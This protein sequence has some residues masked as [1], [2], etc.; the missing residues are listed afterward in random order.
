[1]EPPKTG[2]TINLGAILIHHQRVEQMARRKLRAVIQIG[3]Q[4]SEDQEASAI[5]DTLDCSGKRFETC[6]TASGLSRQLQW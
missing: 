4:S 1:M 5:C 6:A 2:R 3:E